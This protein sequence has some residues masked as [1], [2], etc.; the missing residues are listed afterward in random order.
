[1]FNSL[2]RGY[3][4]ASV[5]NGLGAVGVFWRDALARL[6]N[7]DAPQILEHC[8]AAC[9]AAAFSLYLTSPKLTS[10]LI[11]L[12]WGLILGSLLLMERQKPALPVLL[13]SGVIIG[14]TWLSV[15]LAW[16][17]NHYYFTHTLWLALLTSALVPLAWIK[18]P[19]LV[20]RWLIPVWLIHSGWSLWDSWHWDGYRVQ[21]LSGNANVGAAFLLLGVLAFL[22]GHRQAKWLALVLIIALPFTGSRWTAVVAGLMIP[23][24]FLLRAVHWRWILAGIICAVGIAFGVGWDVIMP[25]FSRPNSLDVHLKGYQ[26]RQKIDANIVLPD[27]IS[28]WMP[29]G[30]YDSGI[31]SVPLRLIA[32]TGYLSM[33]AWFALSLWGLARRPWFDETWWLL[34]AVLLL[35]GLYYFMW[36]GELGGWWW[37]LIGRGITKQAKPE[38]HVI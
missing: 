30:F 20:V 38:S 5:A 25:S 6:H 9:L 14:S 16:F 21:G 3:P 11:P 31:E 29:I 10:L 23:A 28:N 7:L 35:S 22:N 2:S 37:L 4:R 8:G 12:A 33:F 19:L 15:P 34:L 24:I 32:E 27:R 17:F 1:M 36:V 26:P 13:G 18:N